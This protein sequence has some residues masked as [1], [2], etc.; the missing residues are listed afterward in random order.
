MQPLQVTLTSIRNILT[1][2]SGYLKTVSSH[3]LQPYRGCTYGR[4]LCGVGCY[5]RQNGHILQG[6]EWGSFL[7]VRENAA[8]SYLEN[9]HREANWA[10]KQ[11]GK[12]SLFCS[13]STDPFLPQERKYGIT[14]GLLAAMLQS[15]PDLLILQTH[16]ATVVESLPLLTELNARCELRVHISIES[17]RDRLP[18]LPPPASSVADRLA[19][20]DQLRQ[21]GLCVVATVAPLLPID[22]PQEFF[23]RLGEVADRVVIDHFIGG[24]GSSDGSRTLKTPLPPAM[25]AVRTESVTLAYRDDIINIARELLPGRVGVSIDGFA[26]RNFS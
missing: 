22:N 7:E 20:C 16:S 12:F 1:R 19:A 23:R 17:D 26:G 18:G 21:Q 13:S 11:R 24:D 15:P 14:T 6:R 8:A 9:Y 10:R 4:A 25:A 2:T 3:S 5:V